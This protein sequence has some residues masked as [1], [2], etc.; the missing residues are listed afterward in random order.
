[1]VLAKPYL[2]DFGVIKE[3]QEGGEYMS[4]EANTE[5]T[6]PE[7]IVTATPLPSS[8]ALTLNQIWGNI[9]KPFTAIAP[10]DSRFVDATISLEDIGNGYTLDYNPNGILWRINAAGIPHPDDLEKF[11]EQQEIHQAFSDNLAAKFSMIFGTPVVG[12]DVEVVATRL[13][14]GLSKA[15]EEIGAVVE[16]IAK[17]PSNAAGQTPK[18]L[19]DLANSG[20][21]YNPKDIVAI[22][23]TVDGKLVWLETGNA[24]AGL[25]HIMNH[26]DDFAAKGIARNEIKDL[27]MTAL[28]KGQIVGYQGKGT[29]RPIYE[30]VFNGEKQ[31]VAITVGNNGFVVGAN[32]Q[33]LP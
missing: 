3:E 5:P 18:L 11:Y 32:P 29:G 17:G 22:T 14:G 9:I 24:Q 10:T 15:A 2:Q 19:D 20:V 7:V 28:E 31:R 6:L 13:R 12:N 8:S 1:M 4:D 25:E 33:S 16:N 23:K 27:V 21:K 30:V 26:A